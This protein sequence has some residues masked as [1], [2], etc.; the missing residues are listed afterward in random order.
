MLA[1]YLAAAL[2]NLSRNGLYAGVTVAGL[3][4][5]F[6]A[7]ILI[8][9]FVRDEYSWDRHV[10]GHERTYLVEQVVTIPGEKP[11]RQSASQIF[12][13]GTLK[14]QFPQIEATARGTGAPFSAVRHGQ[15]G[16]REEFLISAD[17]DFFKVM[18]LPVVAGDL[19]HALDAPDSV[20]ISRSKARQ[21]FGHDRPLGEILEVEKRPLRVTAVVE[22]HPSA[23]HFEPDIFTSA[24]WADSPIR[25]AEARGYGSL[26]YTVVTYVRLKPG[27][28]LAAVEAGLPAVA[29]RDIAAGA[30][31]VM[32]KVQVKLYLTP[33]ADIH[34]HAKGEGVGK[35]KGDPAIIAAISAIGVLI[36]AVAGIN[37]VTLMTARAARRAVEV[38]VRK[39]AGAQQRDLIVQ[40]IGEA[41]LYVLFAA[42]LAMAL[43]E[44]LTPPLNAFLQRRIEL[45]YLGDPQLV[46][47][48]GGLVVVMALAAGAYPALVLSGF[49]PA[50][51]LKGQ[52][53]AAGGGWSR[54]ALVV[55]QFAVLIALLL[56]TLT[57][58]RQ[59]SFALTEGMKLD[60]AETLRV[61]VSPCTTRLREQ[62][63][64]V[65]G[66]VSA[67]CSSPMVLGYGRWMDSVR[68]GGRAHNVAMNPVDF[69]FLKVYG[70]NLLAGR[71]F[72][73]R[74]SADAWTP[75]GAPPPV[76]INETAAREFGFATPA[77]AIGRR[78]DWHYL[79]I[80]SSNPR[81]GAS[82]IIGVVPDFTFGSVR[83]E[84]TPAL[85]YVALDSP[86]LSTILNVKIEG[87]RAPEALKGLDRAV[88]RFGDGRPISRRFTDQAMQRLYADTIAQG[89]AIAL[90][91]G[92][93]LTIACLGLFALSAY[94]TERRTKEIG[95]R[96]AMG[97]STSDVLK[98]LIWQFTLPVLIANLI[99]WPTA[100]LV[101]RRWLDGF[102][103]RVDLA[104]WTFAAAGAA[105]LAIAWATVFVH[106][107]KVARAKPVGALRYE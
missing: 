63:Q 33:L 87:A 37:F 65:P 12:L 82:E 99:A 66:V 77:Q 88:E 28:S 23:S 98:L 79:I 101:M 14:R 104:P 69:D 94:T 68:L 45:D 41:L 83:E 64:T 27:A 86:Q 57:I 26:A 16:G 52:M 84:V 93:A 13:A 34:L 61:L 3:A 46:V 36:L 105:A 74:R 11:L 54:Q 103:Y 89:V 15:I 107:L 5:A 10:P 20:V 100:F 91:A 40:F 73:A 4:I 35:P 80:T 8:A 96:K 6:T 85:Y 71:S 76:V 22:D 21:Y 97:A 59:T 47:G 78:V 50:A 67:A 51:V 58:Y 24:V 18:P 55:F 32:G 48:L 43:A 90:C 25:R 62:V 102:V 19:A 31:P 1:N 7:A 49:K 44:F 9:L 106:A 42:V 75:T 17:P 38:G 53:V 39:A 29:Q 60:K 2:R 56:G 70:V 95:V 92:I 30:P 81:V 72:D